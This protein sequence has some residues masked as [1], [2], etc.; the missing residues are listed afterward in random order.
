MAKIGKDIFIIKNENISVDIHYS[1]KSGFYY[2]GIPQEVYTLTN[3]GNRRYQ[4]EESLK[5]HLLCSLTEYHEKT[6]NFRKVI[7]YHLH[8]ST[9][10]VLNKLDGAYSGY[11]G[12]KTGVSRQFDHKLN[13]KL[14]EGTSQ[15]PPMDQVAIEVSSCPISSRENKT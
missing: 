6:R 12:I 9:Q 14:L 5:Q 7:S 13:N 15:I 11:S 4:D 8:A 1:Q 3:F 2:R 10:L